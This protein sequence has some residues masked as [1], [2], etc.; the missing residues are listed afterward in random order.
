MKIW[1]ILKNNQNIVYFG[2]NFELFFCHT[3]GIRKFLGQ[4]S[5]QHHSSEN[6]RSLTLHQQGTPVNFELC[7]KSC[8]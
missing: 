2:L 3:H 1:L 6:A 8:F 7:K 4:G 5:N